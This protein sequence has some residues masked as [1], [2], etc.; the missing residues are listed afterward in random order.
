MDASPFTFY[1]II[2]ENKWITSFVLRKKVRMSF[3]TKIICA[4]LCLLLV[5]C[6]PQAPTSSHSTSITE[7]PLIENTPEPSTEDLSTSPEISPEVSTP[8][9]PKLKLESQEILQAPNFEAH[10]PAALHGALHVEGTYILDQNNE[11]FQLRGLST[12]GIQWYGQYLNPTFLKSLRDDFHINVIRLA[13]YADYN[14]A[15]LENQEAYTKILE[16]ALQDA[17]NLGLYVI[18]DWHILEE[19]NPLIHKDDAKTFFNY[20]SKKYQNYSNVIFELCNEPNGNTVNWDDHIKPYAEEILT[21][22][23]TYAPNHLVIVGTP[24]WCQSPLSV[25]KNKLNDP[26]VLYAFHFYANSHGTVLRDQ[27]NTALTTHQLPII[28]SEFGTCDATG[29]GTVNTEQT[30]KW[31]DFLDAHHVS[32]INWSLCDK[33]EASAFLLPNTPSH[34]PLTNDYLTESALYIKSRLLSYLE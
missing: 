14:G 5:G 4:S 32:W 7:S 6:Q 12:H 17:S 26:N 29:S 21:T 10:S 9:P 20:F 34:L 11:I 3:H 22:L 16:D 8:L 2:Q 27:L 23:R 1:N 18:I 13:L 30:D 31:L 19:G 24:R 28:V 15:Y 25:V 33:D